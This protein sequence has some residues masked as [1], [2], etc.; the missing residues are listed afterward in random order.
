M[1]FN[2]SYIIVLKKRKKYQLNVSD[3]NQIKYQYFKKI[4]QSTAR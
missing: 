4:I 2:Y 1:T 3:F